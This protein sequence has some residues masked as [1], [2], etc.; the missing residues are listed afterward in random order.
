MT[1]G[2]ALVIPCVFSATWL[3][4]QYGNFFDA[5]HRQNLT[6]LSSAKRL[7]SSS[8]STKSTRRTGFEGGMLLGF[9]P[10]GKFSRGS[11]SLVSG[12]EAPLTTMGP[13]LV[14]PFL[15]SSIWLPSQYGKFFDAMHRQNF[16][17]P[18]SAKRRL[19]SSISVTSTRRTGRSGGILLG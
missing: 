2:P 14:T 13:T 18:F 12:K 16:T 17:S 10:H 4:S 8:T 11:A 7:L 5:M 19:I 6:S 1:R 15:F 3:P 9:F